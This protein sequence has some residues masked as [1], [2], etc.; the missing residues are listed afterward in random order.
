MMYNMKAC[1]KIIYL[2]LVR[3]YPNNKVA[4]WGFMAFQH[5]LSQIKQQKCEM[6]MQGR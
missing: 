6:K 3:Y 2:W 5:Y 1:A 4:V